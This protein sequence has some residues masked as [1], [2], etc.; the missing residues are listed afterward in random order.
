MRTH[1]QLAR[2][3][4]RQYGVVT[5]RQLAELGYSE[6]AISRAVATGRLHAWHRSVFAVGHQGLIRHGLCMAA[7]M[8]RGEGPLL[9]YQSAAWLW[10]LEQEA[11]DA[12]QRQRALA[13]P[14][15]EAIG[16][17]H[18]PALRAEDVAKPSGMP[19][20]A[21][22]RTLLDYASTAKTYRLE[23]RST[24]RPARPP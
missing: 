20:T 16:L 12:G 7:V 8:F 24:G 13:R 6:D 9:S 10:G 11:R 15:T 19:V 22:P 4:A 14:P 18:C 1:Q 5:C 23:R 2:L 21:V 3:A 17:H